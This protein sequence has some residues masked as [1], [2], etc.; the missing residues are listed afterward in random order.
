MSGLAL[1]ALSEAAEA[2]ESSG[3][4]AWM[5]GVG[6]FAVLA[7]ALYVVTRFNPDR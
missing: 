3:A 2:S 6:A 1:L 4:P 7:I 5:F